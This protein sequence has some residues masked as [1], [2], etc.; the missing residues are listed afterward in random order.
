MKYYSKYTKYIHKLHL[1]IV[2]KI[3]YE[4]HLKSNS[5]LMMKFNRKIFSQDEIELSKGKAAT[6]RCQRKTTAFSNLPNCQKHKEK[7]QK[8]NQ[9]I[10]LP[11][12][13]KMCLWLKL[14]LN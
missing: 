9:D 2:T 11:E 1:E 3:F 14:S 6:V 7:L 10:V 8:L 5:K 4:I 12:H 13:L